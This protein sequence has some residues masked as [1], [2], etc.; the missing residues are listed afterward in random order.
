M[1]V[2]G[3]P[4]TQRFFPIATAAP[5]V[6]AKA[7]SKIIFRSPASLN[8]SK[9]YGNESENPDQKQYDGYRDDRRA[10]SRFIDSGNRFEIFF[11]EIA[12]QRKVL[13]HRNS[14]RNDTSSDKPQA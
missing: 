5:C 14:Q 4:I 3:F 2:I 7:S 13:P 12:N 8:H 9:K 6:G 10:V 1:R 11:P